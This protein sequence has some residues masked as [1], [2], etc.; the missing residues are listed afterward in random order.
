MGD[1]EHPNL[2]PVA[3]RA[4]VGGL[5]AIPFTIASLLRPEDPYP[6]AV[7][8]VAESLEWVLVN[9]STMRGD[10]VRKV[11]AGALQGER[12]DNFLGHKSYVWNKAVATSRRSSPI[13]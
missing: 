5:L 11:A 3:I 6:A 9:Y 4:N 8:R 2:P 12:M 7:E 1:A 10:D 13:R